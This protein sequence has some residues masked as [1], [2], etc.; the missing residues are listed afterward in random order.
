MKHFF[1]VN[2]AAGKGKTVRII[3]EIREFCES[4]GFSYEIEV[5]QYPGHATEIAKKQSSAQT[6][7]I[8]SV[9]GD[10]TLNEVLN[11][12]AGSGSSLA[13]LPCGSGNDFVRSIVGE[14]IPD[15]IIPMTIEGTERLIDYAKAN[16]KYFINIMSLGFDAQVAYQT[17]HFKKLPLISGKMAYI[18]GILST[19]INCRNEQMELKTDED[20]L[21]GKCLLI[22]AGNGRYYG[23][24]VHALPDALIDDSMFDIC[25]VEAMTRLQ[26]LRLF[27]R[28]MKGLHRTIPGVHLLRSK[29]VE[30]TL[31]KP[32]PFNR[33]G[34]IILADKA[35]LEIFH[36]SLPFVYPVGF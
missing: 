29:K 35:V 3:P 34:E 33:D 7:R 18:L 20:V 16:D 12:M 8:Y 2:P 32:I 27:P 14:K 4:H 30:I 6:L 26:I 1:I 24:G 22:A 36:K 15:D 10:G 11:G 23:G 17:V 31:D 28:Y 25:F 9:G 5:T 13:V 21:T 19:I